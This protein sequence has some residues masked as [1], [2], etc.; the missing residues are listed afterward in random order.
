[1]KSLIRILL[2]HLDIEYKYTNT[3]LNACTVHLHK[4]DLND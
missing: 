3:R 1:M 4:S 2:V